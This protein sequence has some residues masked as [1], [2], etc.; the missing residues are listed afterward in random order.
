MKQRY[1]LFALTLLLGLSAA[2]LARAQGGNTL[3]DVLAAD[4]RF[5][6]FN[7]VVQAA[8]LTDL[9]KGAGPYTVLVPTNAAIDALGGAAQGQGRQIILYHILP[10][11]HAAGVL[12][13]LPSARTA[14]GQNLTITAQDG[15]VING[16]ARVVESDIQAGNG[17]IHVLDTALRPGGSWGGGNSGGGNNNAGNSGAVGGAPSQP[18]NHGR[19]D[20]PNQNPAYVS[21]G[22]IAYRSGVQVDSNSCKGM[23]WVLQKQ[24]DGVALVGTDRQTNPYRGDTSCNQALPVLCIKQDYMQPPA[25]QYA[26]GWAFGR[27]QVTNPV[28]GSALTSL[29]TARQIC[30]SAFGDGWRMAEFHDAG[31]G[32]QAGRVSGWDFWAAGSLPIGQRFWVYIND[33]PAN[34]WNSVQQRIGPPNAGT[35]QPVYTADQNPAY[36]SHGMP[37]WQMRQVGRAGCQGHTWTIQRQQDGLVRVG[38]DATSNPFFGDR[39]CG[40]SYPVLCIR[41][42]GYGPPAPANGNNYAAGWSG[43]WVQATGHVS[44]F[45]IDT[46]EKANQLCAASFGAAWRMAT[47]HDGVLGTGGTDGWSLWAYGNLPVGQRFWVAVN[48]QV[49]NPWNR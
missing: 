23:T 37:Q 30:A 21:G 20:D 7:G 27:V 43:G 4:P 1:F 2:G 8:G 24:M 41:V 13:A 32:S 16:A 19:L 35:G 36:I 44:G 40:D 49:A 17:V 3:A 18:A 14:L 31:M 9:L 45:A 46:R 5:S 47:F 39:G 12:A 22:R 42:D 15:I 10:G 26:D 6:S 29:E 38:A 48:D 28:P 11:R 33:Q 34:P 25:P